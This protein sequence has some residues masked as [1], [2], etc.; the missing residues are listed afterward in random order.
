MSRFLQSGY[1]YDG[2][3]RSSLIQDLMDP[4]K[5][6]VGTIYFI[7]SCKLEPCLVTMTGVSRPWGCGISSQTWMKGLAV[8]DFENHFV[9]LLLPF[10][11]PALPCS[12]P[13][14]FW[15][16]IFFLVSEHFLWQSVVPLLM[17]TSQEPLAIVGWHLCK[18]PTPS[19]F[20]SPSKL[21]FYPQYLHEIWYS[22]SSTKA[23][24]GFMSASMSLEK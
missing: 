14:H 1:Q 9:F 21:S 22:L 7:L 2:A 5:T 13:T 20:P 19:S 6:P 17:F 3:W 8:W 18:C 4:L 15:V 16:G 10:S 11:I 12:C 24:R 23:T